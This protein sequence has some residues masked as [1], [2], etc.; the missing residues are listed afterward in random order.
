VVLD[1]YMFRQITLEH[2]R[3]ADQ[4]VRRL[5]AGQFDKIVM[6][7][8]VGTHGELDSA[9]SYWRTNHFGPAVVAAIVRNYRPLANANGY[10]IYARRR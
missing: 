6:F 9:D 4:M 3:W 1:A 5:D 7:R 10:W 8:H 2:P